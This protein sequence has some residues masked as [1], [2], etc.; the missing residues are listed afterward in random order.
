MQKRSSPTKMQRFTQ[1]YKISKLTKVDGHLCLIRIY[2]WSI[3]YWTVL[4]FRSKLYFSLAIYFA[5][6][7]SSII[8][9]VLPVFGLILAGYICRRT[10]RLGEAASSELTRFVV[11]LALPALLFR[12]TATSTWE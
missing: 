10:K 7:M 11:W 12:V 2:L 4:T 8:N 6:L 5:A 3:W 9:I 1:Y